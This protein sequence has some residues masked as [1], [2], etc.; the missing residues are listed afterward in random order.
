MDGQAFDRKYIRVLQGTDSGK[1]YTVK[2]ELPYV[3]GTSEL[4]FFETAFSSAALPGKI[5]IRDRQGYTEYTERHADMVDGMGRDLMGVL[6]GHGI[7]E[8]TTQSLRDEAIAE[9]M[10]KLRRRLNNSGEID[11][12]GAPDPRGLLIGDYLDGIDLSGCAAPTGGTAPQAWNDTYKNNRIVI[13][14]FNTYKQA[15]NTENDK[16]HILFVFR[17]VI[18]K[19]RMNPT[20]T[21]TG[22]YPASELREWLEGAAGDGSGPFS[23]KLNAALGGNYLYT[24]SKLHSAKGAGQWDSYTVWPP[25]EIEV[26]GYQ[27][28]GDELAQANTN[29]Q[30]P[31]FKNSMVYRIKR[32]NGSRE[33]WWEST[34][35]ITNATHI[36]DVYPNGALAGNSAIA[37]QGVS[38]AFCVA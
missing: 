34:P 3:I 4:E 17:N 12:S 8:M 31:I 5:V 36:C 15:G 26:F 27:V 37:V 1:E 32:F 18:A 35:Q 24:I 22:G 23:T 28:Y 16:N 30:L 33:R 38:P 9:T 11:G 25:T 2:N 29:V 19:G 14:G 6:L 10:H 7:G 13:G 20:N 21:N